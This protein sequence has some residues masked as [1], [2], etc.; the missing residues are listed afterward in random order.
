MLC[1]A[2]YYP[3]GTIK[4]FREK[5]DDFVIKVDSEASLKMLLKTRNI[6]IHQK[7]KLEGDLWTKEK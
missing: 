6:V 1:I 3:D 4:L 5:N 2:Y 7:I